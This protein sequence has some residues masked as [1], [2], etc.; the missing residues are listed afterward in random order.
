M[1]TIID[2]EIAKPGMAET[3][4]ALQ[5][6]IKS[7]KAT[8]AKESAVVD[9]SLQEAKDALFEKLIAAANNKTLH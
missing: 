3:L 8:G 5:A 4:K 9:A 1:K 7:Q 2:Q 6:E